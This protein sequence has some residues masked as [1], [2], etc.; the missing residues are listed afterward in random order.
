MPQVILVE[1]GEDIPVSR[2]TAA[3][4]DESEVARSGA[5]RLAR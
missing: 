5:M 3:T 1:G 4:V 2:E